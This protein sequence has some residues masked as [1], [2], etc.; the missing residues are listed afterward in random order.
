MN[1]TEVRLVVTEE[2]ATESTVVHDQI[3]PTMPLAERACRT[4]I[5]KHFGN[6]ATTASWGDPRGDHGRSIQFGSGPTA[7]T[8]TANLTCRNLSLTA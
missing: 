4:R 3:Y 8:V 7:A 6:D 2:R 1:N 5:A